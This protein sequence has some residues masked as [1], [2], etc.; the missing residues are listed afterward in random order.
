MTGPS[1]A[2][3]EVK[4]LDAGGQSLSDSNWSMGSAAKRT[5]QYELSRPIDARTTLNI[6]VVVGQ[7]TVAVPFELRDVE[8]P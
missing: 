7:K 5:I 6:H 8:L 1:D 3:K 4:I 2:I